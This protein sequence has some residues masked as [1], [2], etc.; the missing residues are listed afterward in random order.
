MS[1]RARVLREI[2]QS[3][4]YDELG[5]DYENIDF[6]T[7]PQS[8]SG[9]DRDPSRVYDKNQRLPYV[10]S[11]TYFWMVGRFIFLVMIVLLILGLVIWGFVLEGDNSDE[12]STQGAKMAT[13]DRKLW[14]KC[15][16]D[17][18]PPTAFKDSGKYILANPD[19]TQFPLGWTS[20]SHRCLPLDLDSTGSLDD[21]GLWFDGT[22][23]IGAGRSLDGPAIRPTFS[24][25][26]FL[27]QWTGLPLNV[28]VPNRCILPTQVNSI[29]FVL[30]PTYAPLPCM[31]TSSGELCY[32]Y[33]N[34]NNLAPIFLNNNK[35]V[36]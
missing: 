24:V 36:P 8:R 27:T 26:A 22:L 35:E 10:D 31:C 28:G 34:P 12:I 9:L 18:T 5:Q 33:P 4:E 14:E 17:A 19:D 25:P 15:T 7:D 1:N 23:E 2:L 30:Q 13:L 20:A 32:H 21:F 6:D 11:K 29:Y 16:P 3:N